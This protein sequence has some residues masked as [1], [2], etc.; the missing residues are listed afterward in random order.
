MANNLI[1]ASGDSSDV[2]GFMTIPIYK[3]TG[4]DLMYCKLFS[5]L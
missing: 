4:A 3:A 5:Y 1:I 2:D